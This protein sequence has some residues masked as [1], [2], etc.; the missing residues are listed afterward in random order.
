MQRKLI[1]QATV[2]LTKDVHKKFASWVQAQYPMGLSSAQWAEPMEEDA[3]IDYAA[4][5]HEPQEVSEVE[6]EEV[7]LQ[8][9]CSFGITHPSQ[10]CMH[11][12]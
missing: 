11:V 8:A 3:R 4:A 7:V 6:H 10:Q 12:H 1:C 9:G 2:D 5:G